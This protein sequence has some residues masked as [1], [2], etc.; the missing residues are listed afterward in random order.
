VCPVSY[1]RFVCLFFFF[2]RKYYR[3]YSSV[4]ENANVDCDD[5]WDVDS[6]NFSNNN[7][8]KEIDKFEI[9]ENDLPN[10][11]IKTETDSQL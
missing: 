1:S 7:Y 6:K 2:V 11:S 9:E 5:K 8:I 10:I 4:V 3:S